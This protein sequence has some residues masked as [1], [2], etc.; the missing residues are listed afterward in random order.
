[1]Q[2]ALSCIGGMMFIWILQIESAV[3]KYAGLISEFYESEKAK[4]SLI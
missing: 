1:M 4:P 2:H 3:G